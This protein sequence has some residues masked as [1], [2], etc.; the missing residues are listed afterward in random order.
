MY[1]ILHIYIVHTKYRSFL[2]KHIL[3][4]YSNHIFINYYTFRVSTKDCHQ[5]E[6]N[7]ISIEEKSHGT[8]VLNLQNTSNATVSQ[9][10]KHIQ[11]FKAN[12]YIEEELLNESIPLEVQISHS[13]SQ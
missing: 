10:Q 6:I 7:I 3:K 2:L 9:S 5:N 1:I 4:L 11:K 13:S 12:I 8:N